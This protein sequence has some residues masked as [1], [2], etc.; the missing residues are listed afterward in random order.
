LARVIASGVVVG[1]FATNDAAAEE[2]KCEDI[3]DAKEKEECMKK[4]G[5]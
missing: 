2:K 4:K 1:G 3:K 5:G